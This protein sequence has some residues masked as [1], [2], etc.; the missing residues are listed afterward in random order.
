[1]NRIKDFFGEEL[2]RYKFFAILIFIVVITM[3]AWQ[4]DDS[5]HAYIMAKNLVDGNGFVY[6]IG[7]RATASS[8]PGSQSRISFFFSVFIFLSHLQLDVL[9]H[10]LFFFCKLMLFQQIRS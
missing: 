9:K 1:M 8:C 2:N 5:Y 6:N 10:H 4:S 3:L 7:Q